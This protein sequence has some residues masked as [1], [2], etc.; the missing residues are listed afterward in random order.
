MMVRLL[1]TFLDQVP[2]QVLPKLVWFSTQVAFELIALPIQ[3]TYIRIQRIKNRN[4]D[5]FS[6]DCKMRKYTKPKRCQLRA[7]HVMDLHKVLFQVGFPFKS[8]VALRTEKRW[9]H[10]TSL[11]HVLSQWTFLPIS[12]IALVTLVGLYLPNLE[13]CERKLFYFK[14]MFL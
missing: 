10:A 9:I 11:L 6:C 13:S 1:S 5:L 12:T 3:W 7:L 2:F 4:T 14:W 8:Y